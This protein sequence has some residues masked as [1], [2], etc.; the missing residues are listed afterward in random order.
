MD[1]DNRVI[2][3]VGGVRHET[4]K[5]VLK[6]I[7]A[8][9]LSKLT[10]NL[11]NY[12]PVLKEYFFDRHPDVFTQILNYYRTGKLHYPTNV[13]GPLFEEELEFWGLD[14][15]QV[16]P[17]CWMTY[18]Q[19][20]NTQE[21]LA[22]IEQL[23]NR[24]YTDEELA[25]MFG[26][27]DDYLANNLN[28]WQHLKPKIWSLF[29]QP[30]S[31]S[32]ARMISTI[33]IFFICLST[34]VFCLKAQPSFVVPNLE[35]MT[36]IV[37]NWSVI[38]GSQ[39]KYIGLTQV[40]TTTDDVLLFVDL[41]CNTWF[42]FEIIM[43]FTFCPSKLYFF[44]DT[45]NLIDFVATL[46]F[47]VEMTIR[48]LTRHGESYDTVQFFGIIRIM[49]LFRLAKHSSGLKILIQT[50]KASAHELI[51]LVFVVVLGIVLY[52][53][54]IFYAERS[55]N[56][57]END[58]DSIPLGLWWAIVTMCTIGY[59]DM[60]PKTSVGM[61]IG[62]LCALTGVLTLAL[63]MPVIVSNFEMFYSHAQARAKLPKKR[64]RVLPPEETKMM[65]R[66]RPAKV[67][68]ET[69]KHAVAKTDVKPERRSTL[70][71]IEMKLERRATS[72][73]IDINSAEKQQA[74]NKT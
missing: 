6:K 9:R 45:L 32:A 43:R 34:L 62:C 21:T 2:L 51:L 16:E 61:I 59:G 44:K 72:K 14:S 10:E 4:H 20:R 41:F 5:H 31:S 68:A 60:V 18:T 54:L 46:S 47:F 38:P 7:P 25:V 63:P 53:S 17:C 35:N 37:F 39:T 40:R 29:D 27:E 36:A 28:W 15:N 56:N 50:V 13:C 74:R 52:G 49:R 22:V 66:H 48:F 3:N 64:R 57:P 69:N 67:T 58:F 70:R 19:H 71:A 8:T 12:D 24:T 30:W 23:E 55:E 73:V 26:W 11:A 42:A 1:A 65:L 33:S